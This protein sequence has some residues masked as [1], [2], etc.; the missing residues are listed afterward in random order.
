MKYSELAP[1]QILSTNSMSY[2]ELQKMNRLSKFWDSI[3]NSGDFPEFMKWISAKSSSLFWTFFFLSEYLFE[4]HRNSHSIALL[5][6]VESLLAYM[7][8]QGANLEQSQEILVKDYSFG[9]KRRDVPHFLKVHQSVA[10]K[11]MSNE[12]FSA[13]QTV[14]AAIYNQRQLNR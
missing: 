13:K 4:R 2:L 3:A 7:Q 8:T 12:V 10:S 9:Q 5:S 6:L 14:R 11:N 1:F